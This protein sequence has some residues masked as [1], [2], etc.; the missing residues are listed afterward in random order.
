M[1]AW[2]GCF[3]LSWLQNVHPKCFP[4]YGLPLR[5]A[6]DL[7]QPNGTKICIIVVFSSLTWTRL[8]CVCLYWV[9]ILTRIPDTSSVIYI[10]NQ[11]NLHPGNNLSVLSRIL[12]MS[13]KC[14]GPM[15]YSTHWSR[16][17]FVWIKW[18]PV[19]RVYTNLPDQL[20][21]KV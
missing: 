1:I 8:S 19:T 4:I 5:T 18:F 17:R 6:K 21:K 15:N 20:I 14:S 3:I 10:A 12:W 7:L 11:V 2:S 13:S 9:A 16:K